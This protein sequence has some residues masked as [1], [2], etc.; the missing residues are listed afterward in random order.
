MHAPKRILVTRP[1]PQA[2]A[3]A[4]RLEA[5]RYETIVLPVTQASHDP[6]AARN[7]LTLPHDAIAVTSAEAIR[8]LSVIKEPALPDLTPIVFCIGASTAK[9]ARNAGF[10]H[11]VSADGTGASLAALIVERRA[12]LRNGLLYL[13]GM[14]RSPGFEATLQD[15]GITC[16][17]VEVYSML[18]IARRPAMIDDLLCR[19]PADA[20]L[21]YSYETARL[22]F[23]SLPAKAAEA[24]SGKRMLCLSPHVA[25]AVPDGFGPV[26]IAAA[27]HEDA[28]FDLL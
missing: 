13:A 3:T 12:D 27:P 10:H 26:S 11:V 15:A 17:V 14:P 21:F 1:Q 4:A 23:M 19:Q 25:E 9:A 22:F 8:A 6:Q 20:A 5:L 2:A 7:A 28:L 24:L 18:P 16:H